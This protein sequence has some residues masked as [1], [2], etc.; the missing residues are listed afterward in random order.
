[1]INV[2]FAILASVLVSDGGFERGG[3]GWR[4][5]KETCSVRPGTGRHGSNGLVWECADPSVYRYSTHPAALEPGRAYTFSGWIR[6]EGVTN[7]TYGGRLTNLSVE[8][9]D[10][11]G[12]FIGTISSKAVVDNQERE[13][14]WTKFAGRTPV[15]PMNLGS[16]RVVC[17]ALRGSTGK[18][19]FDDIEVTALAADPLPCM[20][21]SA[22]RDVASS[23]RVAFAARCVFNPHRDR[24]EDLS[25]VFLCVGEKGA[26]RIPAKVAPDG[27]ARGEADV[28]D[29][30]FG[31]H[32]VRV[33]VAR[34]DGSLLG[35]RELVFTRVVSLPRRK[36]TFDGHGRTI[37]D[38]RP[39]FPLGLYSSRTEVVELDTYC[40]GP[41]NCILPYALPPSADALDPYW[42]KGLRVI[43]SVTDYVGVRGSKLKTSSDERAYTSRYL[44]AFKDH[45]AL[46]A[47]Y[48]A[49]EPNV[50]KTANLTARN[51]QIREADPDHP[52]FIVLDNPD[53]PADFVEGYDIIGMD[54]YPI[55]NGSARGVLSTASIYPEAAARGMFG[56]RQ[57]WQVPQAFNWAW[58][59]PWAEK[60][61][62]A[63]MPTLAELRNMNWQ[64]VASG[65]NGLVGWWFPGMVR[66]LRKK[67]REDEFRRV[68]GDVKT[69]YGE[70]AEKIPLLLSVEDAPKVSKR[71]QDMSART[72]R[73]DGTLWLLA[74]NRTYEPV[75][76]RVELSDG[77]SVDVALEGLGFRFVKV[78]ERHP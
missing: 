40:E 63:H 49:D 78:P 33:E 41:F 42:K 58:S 2:A 19:V 34:A 51:L 6:E 12:K 68:W 37:V 64:A 36:V 47:W 71:P 29:L 48:I 44:D 23:G 76:G 57:L 24:A 26:L 77:R 56:F 52:T 72:W 8:F 20:A 18:V 30:A 10:N 65:A 53:R 50:A 32:P 31:S 27:V 13:E 39:F 21:S 66:N 62:G 69:A 61:N 55:G 15:M 70:V 38:G 67:G 45:P 14:G 43:A 60:E 4:I 25:A 73:K 46:L 11:E 9:S 74:V 35:S 28:A 5:A 3:I 75:S 22:Y 7:S 1:M 54:P 16:A 17:C 59:R